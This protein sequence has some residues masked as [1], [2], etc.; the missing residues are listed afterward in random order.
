MAKCRYSN[1]KHGVF[2]PH[3][4]VI[5]GVQLYNVDPHYNELLNYILIKKIVKDKKKKKQFEETINAEC[6]RKYCS[7]CLKN[8]YDLALTE[9]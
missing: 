5:N 6:S 2:L 8:Y 1:K 4:I 3:S 7:F 9:V